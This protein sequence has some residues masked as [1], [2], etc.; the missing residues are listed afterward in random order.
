MLAV[1]Q[2]RWKEGRRS[3]ARQRDH[4]VAVRKGSSPICRAYGEGK[5]R[6]QIKSDPMRKIPAP[7]ARPKGARSGPDRRSLRTGPASRFLLFRAQSVGHTAQAALRSRGFI[8]LSHRGISELPDRSLRSAP[9]VGAVPLACPRGSI[10]TAPVPG[11]WLT[12]RLEILRLSRSANFSMARKRRPSPA[13][14]ILDATTTIGF[15]S[16]SGWKLRSSSIMT[17][18]SCSGS[19][20]AS[21]LASRRHGPERE[22][23]QCGVRSACSSPC[24]RWAPSIRP[25]MSAITKPSS[26]LTATI[27]RLGS[28]VVKG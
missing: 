21:S 1:L 3:G 10:S 8:R 24:P 7:H 9:A 28:N 15:V 12:K 5:P 17:R 16:R 13:K 25:G 26:S 11:R 6:G 2:Q 22:S 4:S 27:P 14:S 23:A 18:K 19:G 20:P